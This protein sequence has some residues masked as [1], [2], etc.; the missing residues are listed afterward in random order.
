MLL[1]SS[2]A[3]RLLNLLILYLGK[4]TLLDEGKDAEL[5]FFILIVKFN[6]LH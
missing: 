5:D 3:L 4:L 1:A 2:V 6:T